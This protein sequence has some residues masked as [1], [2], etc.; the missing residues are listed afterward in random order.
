MAMAKSSIVICF[1]FGFGLAIA[2]MVNDT[3]ARVRVKGGGSLVV[4]YREQQVII[5][6]EVVRIW[7]KDEYPKPNLSAP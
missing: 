2:V 5:R 4:G 3:G 6:S 1:F 7:G